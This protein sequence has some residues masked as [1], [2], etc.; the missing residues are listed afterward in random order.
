MEYTD[1][2]EKKKIGSGGFGEVYRCGCIAV[3]E[4]HKVSYTHAYLHILHFINA[5]TVFLE[6]SHHWRW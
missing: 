6:T 2:D 1:L 4:E 3:K 5:L